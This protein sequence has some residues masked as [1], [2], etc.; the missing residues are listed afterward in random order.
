VPVSLPPP[1]PSTPPAG[2][3]ISRAADPATP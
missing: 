1:P 3:P 2:T